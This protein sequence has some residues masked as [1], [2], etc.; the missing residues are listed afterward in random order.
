[1]SPPHMLSKLLETSFQ[2]RDHLCLY[3]DGA[4]LQAAEH[5]ENLIQNKNIYTYHF[6]KVIPMLANPV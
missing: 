3:L 5:E 6:R 4:F 2:P 1:M